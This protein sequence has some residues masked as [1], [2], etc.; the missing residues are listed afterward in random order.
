MTKTDKLLNLIWRL[1]SNGGLNDRFRQDWFAVYQNLQ[2][3]DF[4]KVPEGVLDMIDLWIADKGE[5]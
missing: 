2:E 3:V 4:D 5:A 1:W